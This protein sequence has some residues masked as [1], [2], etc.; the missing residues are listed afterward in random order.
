MQS[1]DAVYGHR[2]HAGEPPRTVFIGR[3][4]TATVRAFGAVVDADIFSPTDGFA[5]IRGGT[6]LA[7]VGVVG[8]AD[9]DEVGVTGAHLL[10][11]P[12]LRALLAAAL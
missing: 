12:A 3:T 2:A 9:I 7:E 1:I 10:A 6:W 5:A 4:T 8:D 11:A